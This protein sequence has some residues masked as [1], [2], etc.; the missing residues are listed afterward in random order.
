MGEFSLEPLRACVVA[1]AGGTS[2]MRIAL[3]VAAARGRTSPGGGPPQV[4][5][6]QG[7]PPE[8]CLQSRE[9]V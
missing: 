1:G 5:P 4:L 7:L 6:H 3:M 8:R 2:L 9:V